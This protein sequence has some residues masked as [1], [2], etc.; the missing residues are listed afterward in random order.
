MNHEIMPKYNL[1][2]TSSQSCPPGRPRL[3]PGRSLMRAV[4]PYFN[5]AAAASSL[6][7]TSTDGCFALLSLSL[8]PLLSLS[9][10][11][12]VTHYLKENEAGS[13]AADVAAKRHDPSASFGREKTKLWLA[14]ECVR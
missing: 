5:L 6:S 3:L 4:K 11:L 14:S 10:S 9:L 12:S 1:R 2:E 7:L 8:S 13:T